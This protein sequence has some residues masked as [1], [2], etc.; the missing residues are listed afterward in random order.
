MSGVISALVIILILGV[1]IIA[2]EWGHFIAARKS[3]VRV[4]QF[5]IGMGPVIY[6][7]E[8]KTEGGTLFT[9]RALPIGGFCAME[10]ED[11]SS[12]DP[13]AFGN[14]SK[15]KRLIILLA[16]SVMNLLLGLILCFI[17]VIP[18][19]N[20][21]LPI[22]NQVEPTSSIADY[23]Q[24]GD[25]FYAIN[26]HRVLL[27]GDVGVFLSLNGDRPIDLKIKRDGEIITYTNITLTKQ[28]FGNEEKV[29]IGFAYGQWHENTFG[30]KVV[31]AFK[32]AVNN[33]RMV[34]VSLGAI[35]SGSVGADGLMGPVGMGGVVNEVVS[36]S[37]LELID[38]VWN[39]LN[40]MIIIALNLGIVNLLPLPALDGGRIIFLGI[41]A[42]FR[43]PVPPKYEGIVH[44]AGLVFFFGLMIF[45][46]FNDIV[47]LATGKLFG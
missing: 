4:L 5:A 9:I 1:L 8:P 33:C 46:M 2:H 34:W 19:N 24:V 41:E 12:D 3:G 23:V 38:R 18:I 21:Q 7:R 22:V 31:L 42:I 11:A 26:G 44:A 30:D 6:R 10:G 29:R 20:S 45:V 37:E 43:R 36:S 16:G 14:A 28:I 39:I 15:L 35:V 25:E 17:F 47:R 27:N 40:L 13:H 32:T